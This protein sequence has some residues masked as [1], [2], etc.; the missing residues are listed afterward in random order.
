[1]ELQYSDYQRINSQ[2]EY[3][4]NEIIDLS[5]DFFSYNY[6]TENEDGKKFHK[7]IRAK[8]SRDMDK[9]DVDT[10]KESSRKIY[11]PVEAVI[12]FFSQKSN[13]DYF[14]AIRKEALGLAIKQG[15]FF[16]KGDRLRDLMYEIIN[17]QSDISSRIDNLDRRLN[18][19]DL[20]DSSAKKRLSNIQEISDNLSIYIFAFFDVLRDFGI[21]YTE[22]F[23]TPR[24]LKNDKEYVN[25]LVE[26]RERLAELDEI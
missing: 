16:S 3:T 9:L 6:L 13:H 25:F 15:D 17:N 1:M 4:I 2:D 12:E 21:D 7:K 22:F 19:L 23:I 5:K 18:S 24:E 14:E 11:Y 10:Y 26:I 8:I 20:E